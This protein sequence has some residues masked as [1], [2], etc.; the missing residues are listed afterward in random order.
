MDIS[1]GFLFPAKYLLEK[2]NAR[3]C[4]P[5]LRPLKIKQPADA[6][7]FVATELWYTVGIGWSGKRGTCL[8]DLSLPETLRH[9]DFR[10]CGYK[11]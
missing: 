6:D 11:I 1:H 2:Y 3:N 9:L 5:L 8:R 7:R 10:F 4:T